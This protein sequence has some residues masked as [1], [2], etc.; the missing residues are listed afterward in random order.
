ML[1]DFDEIL[2]HLLLLH[3]P[4]ERIEIRYCYR[5]KDGKEPSW[6]RRFQTH[7]E[8]AEYAAEMSSRPETVAVWTNLNRINL[9]A[10]RVGGG[11]AAPVL[12]HDRAYGSVHGGSD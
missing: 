12:P 6:G 9:D 11:V 4:G 8:A 3:R 7:Q 2:R 5:K 10:N 1:V